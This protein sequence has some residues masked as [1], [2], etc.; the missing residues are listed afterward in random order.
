MSSDLSNHHAID[1]SELALSESEDRA[2]VYCSSDLSTQ[3]ADLRSVGR[4][5]LPDG[6][7]S[8]T[9]LTAEVGRADITTRNTKQVKTPNHP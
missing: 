8:M 6:F 5:L 7:A 3:G 4:V 1:L 2:E 9:A